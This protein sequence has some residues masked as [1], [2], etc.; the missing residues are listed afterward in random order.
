VYEEIRFSCWFSNMWL[1]LFLWSFR[2]PFS[3]PPFYIAIIRCLGVLEGLAIQVDPKARVISAAYPYVA[4]R[5]R[6]GPH[7]A[8]GINTEFLKCERNSQTPFIVDFSIVRF[9]QIPKMICKKR[10]DV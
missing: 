5:V 2:Y 1:C 3:L 9:S 4:S 6:M 7:I 8:N 10:Y